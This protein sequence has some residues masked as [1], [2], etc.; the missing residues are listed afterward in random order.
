[1]SKAIANEAKVLF[2]RMIDLR[3]FKK[4]PD[5]LRWASKSRQKNFVQ[6]QPYPNIILIFRVAKRGSR[7][8][9]NDVIYALVDWLLFGEQ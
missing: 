2:W 7:S 6:W 5:F 1:M 3:L 8:G 4:H 9:A